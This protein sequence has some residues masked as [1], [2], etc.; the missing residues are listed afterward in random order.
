MCLRKCVCRATPAHARWHCVCLMLMMHACQRASNKHPC[1]GAWLASERVCCLFGA[2]GP[3]ACVAV[4]P[5]SCLAAACSVVVALHSGRDRVAT[6]MWTVARLMVHETR[7]HGCRLLRGRAAVRL[8]SG[9]ALTAHCPC[10]ASVRG[11]LPAG[12]LSCQQSVKDTA[13]AC[14]FCRSGCAAA[15]A[16]VQ[17]HQKILLVFGVCAGCCRANNAHAGAPCCGSGPRCASSLACAC[18]WMVSARSRRPCSK[19]HTSAAAAHGLAWQREPS[20]LVCVL[21]VAP[22]LAPTMYEPR[23][24]PPRRCAIMVCSTVVFSSSSRPPRMLHSA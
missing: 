17:R 3:V 16:L 1:S 11:I 20:S 21:S 2:H 22:R 12:A 5:R 7:L 4:L 13:G 23:P 24:C 18:V 8:S 19:Q 15:C 6:V 14:N 10:C 9:P